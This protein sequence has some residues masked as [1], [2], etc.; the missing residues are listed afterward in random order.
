MMDIS[1]PDLARAKK[2]RRYLL[3]AGGSLAFFAATVAV[4]LLEP[5][6]PLVS[7]GTIYTD[8]VK[9]GEMVREVHG[10][11]TLVPEE[12][13]W[14]TATTSGRIEQIFLLPGVQ[15]EADTILVELSNPE[16]EQTAF[17]AELAWRKADADV[18]QVRI[19]LESERL[20]HEADIAKYESDLE[21]STLKAE[22]DSTLHTQGLVS[23]L[24]MR[25][26]LA[27]VED[28]K[29]ALVLERRRL[30]IRAQLAEAQ[31]RV[32]LLE[33]DQ[34]LKGYQLKQA[35]VDALKV[36]AGMRGVLQ[37]LGGDQPLQVGQQISQGASVARIADPSRLKA[38]IRVPETQVKDVQ[39]GQSATVDTYNGVVSGR[40]V[41][42][43]PVV[44]EGTVTVDV[45]LD[46]PPPEGSRPDL[47]VDATITIERLED[48]AFVGRPVNGRTGGT[49]NLFRLANARAEAVRVPVKLGRT[50]VNVIEVID[51][52]S[53]G[54]EVILSDM[55]E[56]DE[57]SRVRLGS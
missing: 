34:A 51:G 35:Q 29:R 47:S 52:L 28:L 8:V 39:H 26:S 46:G 53:E 55:S 57:Y 10:Y 14:I 25:Q 48:V 32:A 43:D 33:R 3:L 38:E 36:R 27:R 4:S 45:A 15:V 21:Q 56:W 42:I 11:G 13:R 7:R 30:E 2:R 6:P 50:S 40:V 18:E 16:L 31:L 54:D 23:Q 49:V 41:R 37:R 1:R 24:E 19:S 44:K 12:V 20:E 22:A 17:A 9:R 5:A